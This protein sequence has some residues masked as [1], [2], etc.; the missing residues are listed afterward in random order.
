MKKAVLYLFVG[1]IGLGAGIGTGYFVNKPKLEQNQAALS[2]LQAKLEEAEKTGLEK[3]Q[4]AGADKTRLESELRRVN[5]EL[6]KF[7]T[8]YVRANTELVRTSAELKQLKE[9][10]IPQDQVEQLSEQLKQIAA[11]QSVSTPV[12]SAPVVSG[13]S[14]PAPAKPVAA[15]GEYVI[16]DG[17]NLWKIAAD[18]LGSG[19][20]YKEI[21]A[22]NPGLDEKKALAV[23]SKIKLPAR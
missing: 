8:E 9:S 7:K 6:A 22:V 1:A 5:T 13:G 20:R 18:Q 23:G 19:V 16:K 21:L 2:E 17:D 15:A 12:Q 14:T 4:Q 11:S 3:L 10:I